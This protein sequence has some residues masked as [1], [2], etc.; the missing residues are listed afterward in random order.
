MVVTDSSSTSGLN[1][2]S[3]GNMCMAVT[4]GKNFP[5]RHEEIKRL[6]TVL[7]TLATNDLNNNNPRF[8]TIVQ[9]NFP[10]R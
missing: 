4:Y 2:T 7:V 10:G 3:W 5:E 1:A 8:V 9:D 6:K